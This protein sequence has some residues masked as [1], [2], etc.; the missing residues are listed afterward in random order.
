M[1]SGA[2]VTMH[3]TS[4]AHRGH[5]ALIVGKSGSGKSG[6]ALQLMAHGAVLLADDRVLVTRKGDTVVAACPSHLGGLI[7]ARGIG[8]LPAP[9]AP[10][11]KLTL[12]VDLDQEETER[13]PPKRKRVLLDV[14]LDLV[15][16][17]KADH[18]PAAILLY[19]AQGKR[20]D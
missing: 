20:A 17:V 9:A 2:S 15:F 16:R 5:A 8:L 1:N 11:T 19:L 4:V 3:A 14:P 13:L 18:F 6:L 7:E 10:P 12:I